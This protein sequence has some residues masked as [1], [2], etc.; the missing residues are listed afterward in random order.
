[1]FEVSKSVENA[2][3]DTWDYIAADAAELC[4]GSD[5]IAMEFVI[6]ADRLSM[7]GFTEANNTVKALARKHGFGTVRRELARRIPLL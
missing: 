4:E 5:E 6:D 2:I 1:M 7:Q 3:L